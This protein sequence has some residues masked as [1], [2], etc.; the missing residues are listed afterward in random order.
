M[1]RRPFLK[2]LGAVAGSSAVGMQASLAG[3]QSE[4]KVNGMPYRLLG[5]TGLQISTI[6]FPGLSLIRDPQ[7]LCTTKLHEAIE[8]GVNYFDNAPAYGNRVCETKM[9]IGM[10]DIPRDR[11]YLA[12]KTKRRDKDGARE[13]L[14]ESLRLLKTDHFDVYQMHYLRTE[15]EVDEAFGPNGCMETFLKAQKE[16]KIRFIGFSSHTTKSALA[17]L[18]QYEFDSI[19]FP[20]N[21]VEYYTFDFGKEVMELAHKRGT[22]IL[23]M[24]ATCGG[25]WPKG[26]KNTR[27]WWYRPLED[28]GEIDTAVRFT[29][30][31]QGVVTAVPPS[32]FDLVEKAIEAAKRF[33][34]ITDPE[35]QKLVAMA[36][37]RLSVFQRQQIAHAGPVPHI[38]A[39]DYYHL[40][41]CAHA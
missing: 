9:G 16:G 28:S 38:Q 26:V 12:C 15:E 32:F 17:A 25:L 11:Y 4:T 6:C 34:P 14:E 40:M 36:K 41:P 1:K 39:D 8:K 30:S 13:E 5:R 29:L 37:E 7:E 19:M 24:K 10:Q 22:A 27:N 31:H 2:I 21:F 18:R 3:E 33:Q 35:N 20:I 23:G